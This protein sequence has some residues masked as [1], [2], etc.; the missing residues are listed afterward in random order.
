MAQKQLMRRSGKDLMSCLRFAEERR[1]FV[2]NCSRWP[3]QACCCT[4]YHGFLVLLT[5][6]LRDR[7]IGAGEAGSRRRICRQ[8]MSQDRA[9]IDLLQRS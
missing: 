6:G 4:A 1:L 2:D 5:I 9:D 3:A 7:K 8:I